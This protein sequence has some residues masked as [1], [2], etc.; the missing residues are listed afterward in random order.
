MIKT[1]WHLSQK[2]KSRFQTV[3][4]KCEKS[5]QINNRSAHY[6]ASVNNGDDEFGQTFD[7]VND[8]YAD[9]KHTRR[10]RIWFIARIEYIDFH[11]C[12]RTC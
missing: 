1:Q 2:K 10:S 7:I 11:K 8:K 6:I 3:R 9:H 12:L 5:K 4:Q